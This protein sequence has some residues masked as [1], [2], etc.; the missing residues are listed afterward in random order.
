MVIPF[1][2]RGNVVPP[3][4]ARE[5]D[6]NPSSINSL[7]PT[8]SPAPSA[9]PIMFTPPSQPSPSPSFSPVP[10]HHRRRLPPRSSLSNSFSFA[11]TSLDDLPSES[12]FSFSLPLSRLA[13][14]PPLSPAALQIGFQ[15]HRGISQISP[16][17]KPS[18]GSARSGSTNRTAVPG[19]T[20]SRLAEESSPERKSPRKRTQSDDEDESEERT[21]GMVDSM[22]LW[23]HDAI[24]QHL[25][26]TAGFWGD[27]ILSWTGR[28]C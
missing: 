28:S 21:W 25:Y 9:P 27:K 1:D 8:F 13:P 15:G 20:R 17:A 5:L 12:E 16:R 11:P 19:R 7:N 24:M 18:P 6:P 3:S 23:R 4:K 22:R 2:H 26:E 10:A 14:Q